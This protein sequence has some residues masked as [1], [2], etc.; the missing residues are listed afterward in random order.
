[1]RIVVL[2][3]VLHSAISAAVASPGH[4]VQGTGTIQFMS[5]LEGISFWMIVAD[6]GK[7]YRVHLPG[8]FEREGLR[9]RFMGT[10]RAVRHGSIPLPD[11]LLLKWIRKL[12]K[13]ELPL[14]ALR[15]NG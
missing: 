11:E 7:I 4:R 14:K 2:L 15:A 5:E 3:L 13:Q 12:G 9:V 6:G 10:S 8:K 1:M